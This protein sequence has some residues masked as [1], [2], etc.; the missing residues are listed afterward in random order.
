MVTEGV[1]RS[2]MEAARDS[3]Q[4]R[5]SGRV[6]LVQERDALAQQKGFLIYVPVYK[7][8]M[9]VDTEAQRRQALFGFVYSPFRGG[10]FLEEVN[11]EKNYDVSFQVYDGADINTDNLLS[12]PL[13]GNSGEPLFSEKKTMNVAGRDWTVIYATKPS[14]EKRS[15]RS[16]HKYTLII[17]G[18]LSLLFFAV[19]RSEIQAR[20]R[21][22]RSAEEAQTVRGYDSARR[23]TNASGRKQRCAKL[24]KLCAMRINARYS[25][26]NACS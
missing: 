18:L 16:L 8:S 11:R 15:S 26:T 12:F 10:D 14:F 21:A 1:R 25:N 7:K 22:E 24:P 19:T 5:A 6:T 9:P 20:S 23:S 13:Q 4:P 2:A 17:G 3:G